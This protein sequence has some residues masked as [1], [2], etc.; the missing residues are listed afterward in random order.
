MQIRTMMA[1][2]GVLLLLSACGGSPG[3]EPAAS[4]STRGQGIASLDAPAG[5]APVDEAEPAEDEREVVAQIETIGGGSAD[6]Y[7]SA[8]TALQK[9]VAAG[10]KAAVSR[11]VDF[12][13]NIS[14][15]GRKVVMDADQ[16]VNDYDRIITPAIAATITTQK[17]SQVLVNTQGILFGRGEVWLSGSCM[18]EKCRKHLIAIS[19]IE[20]V[21]EDDVEFPLTVDVKLSDAA[22]ERLKKK[23]ETL[24]VDVSY[25]G[26]AAP[27][28][29]DMA[30]DLG[31][32]DLG[33]ASRELAPG[34]SEA[35]FD[36]SRFNRDR[37]RLIAGGPRL[38]IN[39]VSG[40]RSSDDNM[41]ECD[42]Y[43]GRLATATSSPI[44]LG[45]KLL[46]GE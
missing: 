34:A 33:S 38:N 1:M 15:G 37:L 6:E 40:R 3:T 13:L 39:V 46:G 4:A 14:V 8:F 44:S 35:V 5:E 23:G 10:D 11:L 19:Q 7:K 20:E 27:A 17:F 18:D 29:K 21:G 30:D 45:C 42:I 12:P 31:M 24:E 32:V 16:F 26:F 25:F 41:L 22:E 28:A 2:L 43:E 36:G 9:A